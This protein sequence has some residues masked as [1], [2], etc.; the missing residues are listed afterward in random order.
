MGYHGTLLVD[1]SDVFELPGLTVEGIDLFAPGRRRGD[2]DEIPGR[3]GALPASGLQYAAY[4]FSV[5]VRVQGESSAEMVANL[6]AVIADLSGTDGLVSLTRRLASIGGGFTEET[7]QGRF[8][9]SSGFQFLNWE[10][11]RTELQFVNLDGAWFDGS[12]WIV[13]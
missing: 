9:G 1:G 4:A 12:A 11:Q 3:R 5:Q 7:A 13:P 6:R 10:T 8:V 2:D